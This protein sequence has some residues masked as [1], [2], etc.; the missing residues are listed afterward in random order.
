MEDSLSINVVQSARQLLSSEIKYSEVSV[1]K[2]YNAFENWAASFDDSTCYFYRLVDL[3]TKKL[4]LICLVQK[5]LVNSA[6]KNS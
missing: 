5:R 6:L 1:K 3:L 4:N 2:C